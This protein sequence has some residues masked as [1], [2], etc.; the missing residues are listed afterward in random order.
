M[1]FEGD[2]DKS[3]GQRMRCNGRSQRYDGVFTLDFL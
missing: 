2:F 1:Q 3:I